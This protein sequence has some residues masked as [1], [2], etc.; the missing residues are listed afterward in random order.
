VR[1]R[2]R[3]GACDHE[4]RIFR[5][6]RDVD[7]HRGGCAPFGCELERTLRPGVDELAMRVEVA[8]TWT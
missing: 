6:G 5:N 7:R 4:A 8:G 2:I 3:V 1:I